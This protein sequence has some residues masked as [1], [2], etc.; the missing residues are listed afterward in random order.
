MIIPSVDIVRGQTVQLV[1]GREQVL[2]AG[3]P[4]VWVDRFAI[5][6]EVAIVDLDAALGRGDQRELIARLCRRA[7]CRVGGG[8]RN[9][10]IARFWLDAGAAKIVIGTAAAPE[11]L[12]QLPRDRTI[13]A[14]DAMH[15]E[16]VVDGWRTATGKR[17]LDRIAELRDL[18]GGFLVTFVERE[19]RMGGIDLDAVR[20]II[21]A[22]GP[23]RVT[24]AGGITTPD[25]IAQLDALGAD[26]QV[27]MALYTG[28]LTLGAAIGAPL[29]SDRADGLFATVVADESGTA[30]GLAWSSVETLERAVT[31]RRG[32]YHSRRRGTWIKGEESGATQELLR[33]DLDCDRDAL[34]FTVRQ[35][36]PGFCHAD[37][38]TCWGD[39]PGLTALERTLRHRRTAPE[40]GSYTRRLWADDA[41]LASKLVEE[42]AELAAARERDDV[43]GEAADVLYFAMVKMAGAGVSLADVAGEL[44]R[45]SRTITRRPG[46]AKPATPASTTA[47]V[48]IRRVTPE[49]LPARIP[50]AIDEATL[51]GAREIVDAVRHGGREKL[52]EYA[53]RFDGWTDATPWRFGNDELEAARA[54]LDPVIRG[55]LERMAARILAFAQAQRGALADTAIA[56]SGG[57]AGHTVLPMA[58]AGCY[59]P[60]GRFPLPSSLL[61][62]VI[63][64]RAAGVREVWVASPRPSQLMLAAAAIAGATGLIGVGGAHAIAAL[65]YG[66]EDIPAC[67]V[68]VGPGNRWV[69]AA[70]KCIAGDVGIDFLAGPSELIVLADEA[71]D[72]ALVSADLLAQAEHDVDALPILVTTS[73]ALVDAVDRELMR[74]LSLLP[75]P[76]VAAASLAGGYAVICDDLDAAV[77]VVD[78]I[79]PEH[80]QLALRDPRATAD[81]VRNAGALFLGESSAE[82]FGDYG[83]GPNHVLPTGGAARFTGGLSVLHFLRVRTWLDIAEPARLREDTAALARLE[84]LEAHARAAEHRHTE[85]RTGGS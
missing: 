71:A 55:Q 24:I 76:A 56:V 27:G 33:V 28:R 1:G 12:R 62:G 20:G 44:A 84:G 70:K 42:A 58:R 19:G 8:I 4:Q 64:A 77:A 14:L 25:D 38:W 63:T 16:V 17:V 83:A 60:A 10:E 53:Q 57:R 30:L 2:D 85:P 47:F 72:P 48:A 50:S 37:T 29:R 73:E 43:V 6:G 34:R 59:A 5:A 46:D 45:R 39:A 80:L 41:L 35:A 52:L 22:A 21:A 66:I 23:A 69:T 51:D 54:A 82:V 40:S 78:A 26:A 9:I 31:E 7:P 32:V 65:A 61:M 36:D 67:D 3:D 74:Q 13:A 81:R 75:E 68:V 15:G 79:A 11:I 49:T 18:V